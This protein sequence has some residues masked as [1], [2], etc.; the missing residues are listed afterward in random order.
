MITLEQ[1]LEGYERERAAH[2]E[3]LRRL[4]DREP[5]E[6]FALAF[7]LAATARGAILEA[8]RGVEEFER[9]IDAILA[10]HLPAS[11][12]SVTASTA[13]RATGSTSCCARRAAE[14][15][16]GKVS[17]LSR[18]FL[19][20]GGAPFSP[21]RSRRARDSTCGSG[22]R[23]AAPTT[24]EEGHMKRLR[25]AAAAA[26]S[27]SIVAAVSVSS[28]PRPPRHSRRRSG[29]LPCSSRSGSLASGRRASATRS[30][31]A[32]PCTSGRG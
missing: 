24:P 13:R 6:A 25:L 30:S 8:E 16:G 4:A 1:V 26:L 10:R 18:R 5:A 17:G 15:A 7:C 12:R 28:A 23:T 21:S 31:L 27:A 19:S 20:P 32:G 9:A 11:A 22:R 14:P 2:K 29:S 3:R